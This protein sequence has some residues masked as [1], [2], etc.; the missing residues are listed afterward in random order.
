MRQVMWVSIGT[1]LHGMRLRLAGPVVGGMLLGG[2]CTPPQAEVQ[3]ER[4]V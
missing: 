4:T 3:Q 2:G 1:D